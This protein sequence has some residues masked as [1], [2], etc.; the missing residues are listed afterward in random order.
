M[1]GSRDGVRNYHRKNS[2]QS[3]KPEEDDLK[4]KVP[5]ANHKNKSVHYL[6]GI[7]EKNENK[8]RN[9]LET[10]PKEV[11]M[12]LDVTTKSDEK[13]SKTLGY[14][15]PRSYTG[16]GLSAKGGGVL[17]LSFGG[18]QKRERF[19][20]LWGKGGITGFLTQFRKLLPASKTAAL[21]ITERRLKRQNESSPPSV[22]EC[23]GL[24]W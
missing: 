6:R 3:I 13:T 19:V 15:S 16:G 12:G 2:S 20:G 5:T 11:H 10:P 23:D 9:H 17:R 8:A 14:K 24:K 21:F 4:K 1:G 18:C 22:G 7:I